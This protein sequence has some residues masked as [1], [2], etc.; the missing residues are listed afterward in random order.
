MNKL[1][2]KLRVL[3]LNV[4]F[5]NERSNR[6]QLLPHLFGLSKYLARLDDNSDETSLI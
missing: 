2:F 3:A 4:P 1:I 6:D 5:E